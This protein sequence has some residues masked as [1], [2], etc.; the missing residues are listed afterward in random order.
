MRKVLL[1]GGDLASGKSTFSRYLSQ[2]LNITL[3]NK[4]IIKEIL[5]DNICAS[6]REENLKLSVISFE[7]IEY[8][9]RSSKDN[10]IIESNFKQHEIDRLAKY[11]NEINFLTLCFTADNEVL[12]QRFLTRLNDDRHYVHKSQDF[13]NI[14]DFIKVL[15]NLRSVNYFGNVIKVNTNDFDHLYTN[16]QLL[17][18]IEEFLQK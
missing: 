14:N 6:N 17:T 16:K 2:K 3:I 11:C 1:I 4:D 12:H 10:L 13:T 7:L 18:T 15:E 8:F 9:L 5:G